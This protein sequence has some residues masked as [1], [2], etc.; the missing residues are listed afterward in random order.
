MPVNSAQP[1]EEM[2]NEAEKEGRKLGLL[3]ASLPVSDADKEALLNLLPHFTPE[4]LMR[5]SAILEA[6]YLNQ[7]S[8][9]LDKE[10][11]ETLKNIDAEHKKK[12][13]DLDN[14]TL[15]T[16]DELGKFLWLNKQK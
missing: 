7:K 5:F 2:I 3:I 12:M 8:G 10:L 16:L 15:K 9:N 6:T 11:V 14:K 4:Q 13:G 1:S